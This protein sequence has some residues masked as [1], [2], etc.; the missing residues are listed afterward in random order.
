MIIDIMIDY[1]NIKN[2]STDDK[3]KIL[4][5]I[6]ELNKKHKSYNNFNFSFEKKKKSKYDALIDIVKNY[7]EEQ[8]EEN[9]RKRNFKRNSKR[10]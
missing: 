10:R 9:E 7:K 2:D 5:M 4:K 6:E 1:E 3:N 8:S